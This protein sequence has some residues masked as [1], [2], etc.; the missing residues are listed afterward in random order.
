MLNH[1]NK[2]NS[3]M[4]QHG[5]Q[6]WAKAEASI[7][8]RRG[9]RSRLARHRS[10]A[11]RAGIVALLSIVSSTASAA[12][13]T[14]ALPQPSQVDAAAAEVAATPQANEKRSEALEAQRLA[15]LRTEQAQANL[16]AV[17]EVLDIG[18]AGDEAGQLLREARARAPAPSAVKQ[19]V[20]AREREL[21]EAR[22][23]R[24]RLLEQRRLSEDTEEVA[25]LSDEVAK[26]AA[27]LMAVE[28][29]L[30]AE[31]EL[32]VATKE[33]GSPAPLVGESGLHVGGTDRDACA[34]QEEHG[35]ERGG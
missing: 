33:L 7:G 6:D 1:D 2:A 9:M 22:L 31:R 3:P 32:M 18:L 29:A 23:S 15:E 13:A 27:Y 28:G 12:P 4:L 26:Q 11:L 21:A 25:R 14:A 20:S 16:E 17:R 19:Q 5:E 30:A 24:V 8:E 10:V 34:A 35:D